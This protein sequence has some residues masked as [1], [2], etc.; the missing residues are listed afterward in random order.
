M[1]VAMVFVMAMLMLMLM[2][3]MNMF[4]LMI[5]AD[6]QPKS[7]AHQEGSREEG[8]GQWLAKKE[9]E[10]GTKKGRQREVGT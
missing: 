10:A 3:V 1:T 7:E 5:F 4:V 9:G 6:M 2:L 8:K